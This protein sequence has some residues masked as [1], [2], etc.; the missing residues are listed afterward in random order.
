MVNK[1]F[2]YYPKYP[3]QT[4]LYQKR[5]VATSLKI[6]RKP[7]VSAGQKTSHREKPGVED[8]IIAVPP[9]PAMAYAESFQQ[10]YDQ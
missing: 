8:E 1:E 4:V 10:I 3:A 9:H 6:D 5:Q 7:Y 2:G